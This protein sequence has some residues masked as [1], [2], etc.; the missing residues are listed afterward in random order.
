MGQRANNR[1]RNASLDQKKS[2]SAGR[3]QN[4]PARAAISDQF[5]EKPARGKTGGAFGRSGKVSRR[6]SVGLKGAGGG[7]GAMSSAKNAPMDT[8]RSS[9]RARKRG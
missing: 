9:Q 2:R 3:Q 7:G 8:R 6:T 4:K 1:G 5:N